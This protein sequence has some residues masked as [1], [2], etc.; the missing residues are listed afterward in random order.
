MRSYPKVRVLLG[1]Q[2]NGSSR[3][4]Q[5]ST[6]KTISSQNGI[7]RRQQLSTISLKLPAQGKMS[8]MRML[9]RRAKPA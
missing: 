2:F 4:D 8:E 6:D 7:N 3:P 1:G 5:P 9:V